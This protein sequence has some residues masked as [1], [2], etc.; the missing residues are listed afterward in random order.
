MKVNE[1]V[2]VKY[3]KIDDILFPQKDYTYLET[4]IKKYKILK[5]EGLKVKV[6]DLDTNKIIYKSY[7]LLKKY[8]NFKQL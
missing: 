4:F 3:S 1:I 6:E 7:L 5:I 2:E 8:G